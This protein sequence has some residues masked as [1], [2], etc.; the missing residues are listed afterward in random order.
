[1]RARSD[2]PD[3]PT[4]SSSSSS[5]PD[6]LPQLAS[7][8]P[9]PRAR[10]RART[11]RARPTDPRRG[12][13]ARG[14]RE[15]PDRRSFEHEGAEC[16]GGVRVA[17]RVSAGAGQAPGPPSGIVDDVGP[18]SRAE[19]PRA[20]VGHGN[21]PR[22]DSA[23][24]ASASRGHASIAQ[25][26]KSRSVRQASARPGAGSTQRN[27]PLRPKC[28]NVPRRV[29]RPGPVRALGV[30]ELEA[31]PPVVRIHAPEARQDAG[32]AGELH[33]RPPR[34]ASRARR[35]SARAARARRASSDASGPRR[36]R[37]AE[38]ASAEAPHALEV[39]GE[40][41]LGARGDELARAARSRCSSRCAAARRAIGGSPSNG[42]PDACA[43]RWRTV[44]PGGPAGSSR[45]TIPSSAATSTASAVAS[46]VTDAHGKTRARSPCA[47]ST[48]PA[49]ATGA[50]AHGHTFDLPQGL[51]QPTLSGWIAG[52]SR[53]EP[54]SRS[55]SATRA[56]SASGSR[57]G[58]R[59]PRR[60]CPRRR[61]A[62]QPVRAGPHLPRDHRTGTRRGGRDAGHVVRTR[63][64]VTHAAD[65]EP[66]GGRTARPRPAP[67]RPSPACDPAGASDRG[68]GRHRACHAGS[69]SWD[70]EARG[71]DSGDG[72]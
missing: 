63:I 27:V 1:M 22:E 45:S 26:P 43:S 17:G 30:A 35:A 16:G 38:P 11:R 47:A 14:G 68:R 24:T 5:Q 32:E 2:R 18:A 12:S 70:S 44:E 57:C 55:V 58:S 10:P 36:R 64:Y 71:A 62:G 6:L 61:P 13:S 8:A 72:G 33:A 39:V 40:R 46:F 23:S 51:H 9:P 67:P 59:A 50:C 42:R 3:A 52:A 31:E 4:K 69:P 28:P 66:S 19:A 41:H 7:R 49:T 54:R 25:S 56:P 48:R 53:P 21:D 29:A 65:I 15:A 60:S 34:R 20:E 37:P